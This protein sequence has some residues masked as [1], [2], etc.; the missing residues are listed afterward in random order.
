MRVKETGNLK[1][2]PKKMIIGIPMIVFV[3]L[4]ACVVFFGIRG[5]NDAVESMDHNKSYENYEKVELNGDK[6]YFNVDD[7]ATINT[8]KIAVPEDAAP[9]VWSF[10][11]LTDYFG[12]D[13]SKLAIPSNFNAGI[14]NLKYTVYMNDKKEIVFD[15]TVLRY[16]GRKP[17]EDYI[18]ITLS[19]G[20][21]PV[22]DEVI[23]TKSKVMSEIDNTQLLVKKYKESFFT[24]FMYDGIGYDIHTSNMEKKDFVKLL[25]SIIR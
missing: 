1:K 12:R 22:S 14:N 24:S 13:F 8:S 17:A 21:I 23:T 11:Q 9:V 16:Q 7:L 2:F 3:L 15:N 19:K 25:Q 10:S 4:V 5:K 20:K 18:C 6:I